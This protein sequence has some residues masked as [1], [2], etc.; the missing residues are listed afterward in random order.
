[1]RKAMSHADGVIRN[2]EFSA[3]RLE[4]SFG[5]VYEKLFTKTIQNYSDKKKDRNFPVFF[6][7]TKERYPASVTV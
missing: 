7:Y 6:L 4:R 1:M 5:A 3:D 2:V